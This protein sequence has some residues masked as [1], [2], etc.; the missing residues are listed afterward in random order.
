MSQEEI[1]RYFGVS[2]KAIHS[3]MKR[4]GISTRVAV[5]R[6][7]CGE[8]NDNWKG[9][10]IEYKGAHN[11]VRSVRGDPKICEHCGAKEKGRKI[12][13]AN[14]NKR[15]HDPFDYIALCAKCH[16]RFDRKRRLTVIA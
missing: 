4:H 11:R 3:Y 1:G 12:H 5:K 9:N 7:Q 14:L 15:Y 13:W 10:R 6:N 2:Q 8:N 16:V